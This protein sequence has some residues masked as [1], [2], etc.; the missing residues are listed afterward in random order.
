MIS[1]CVYLFLTAGSWLDKDGPLPITN[2]IEV[3]VWAKHPMLQNP[4]AISHDPYGRL[5]VTEAN[6]RKT[7]D[8]DVRNMRDLEPAPWP[9][10]DYSIQSIEERRSILQEYLA[11][12]SPHNNPWMKDYDGDGKKDWLDLK[13][14]TER[15]N[16]LEDTNGD[17][18]A[19]KATIF[20]ED[21]N[22]ELTGTAGG[23]L[24]HQGKV[25]FTVIPDLWLLE[26][27]D[28]DG[29]ADQR[30]SL[31][32]GHGVHIGQ[33]GHDLHGLTVGPDGRIYWSVGDKGINVTSKEGRHFFY[34]NQGL[35]MRSEPDGSNFEVF[36]MGLRNCQEL[37]FDNF[38]N[39]FCV[40]NDG[41]F[42]GERERLLYVTRDSDTGWRIN[43]QFNHTNKWAKS[44]RLPEYN[45]WMEEGLHVPHFEGQAAYI[46]PPLANYSDGPAGFI[47]NPGTALSEAYED[48]YF[49][50]QFPGQKITAF[51]L[52]PKGAAFEMVNEHNFQGGFMATGFSF[53]PEGALYVA[54]WAGNWEPN[55]EGA[56]VK[57]DVVENERHPLRALTK[58]LIQ[59]D[60]ASLST[61]SLL[62]LLTY[63]DRRVR[64]RAQFELVARKE[65]ALLHRTALDN[66]TALL[67]R[68]H[69]LWGMGQLARAI[70][71]T[72]SVAIADLLQDS[73][74]QVVI[75]TLRLIAEAPALFAD[76]EEAVIA[77]LQNENLQVRFH[78]GQTLGHIGT[79]QAIEPLFELLASEQG[80]DPFIRHGAVTG[81]AGIGYENTLQTAVSHPSNSVRLGAVLALRRLKSIHTQDFLADED[82]LIVLAAA[83]AIHDDFGIPDAMPALARILNETPHYS[84]EALMRRVLNANLRLG[85]ERH[86]NEVLTFFQ[87]DKGNRE[88]KQEALDILLTWSR[89][90]MLD[91]VERRHRDIEPRAS[92]L[93]PTLLNQRFSDLFATGS[94]A[95]DLS[96][97]LLQHYN[98]PI[99][100]GM[101][102]QR[103]ADASRS[104]NERIE[105]F[106]VLVNQSRERKAAFNTAFASN[107]INL[108]IRA[109]DAQLTH[110]E[111]AAIKQISHVLNNS[112]NLLQRQHAISLLANIQSR[113]GLKIL[114]G[115]VEQLEQDRID[116]TEQLD[117]FLAATAHPQFEKS[118]EAVWQD[119]GPGA[120]APYAF[121][122]Y[123]GNAI[124]GETVFLTHAAAQ[125]IRCHAVKEGDGSNVG[126][127]LQGIGSK[128]DR[129]YLLESLVSPSATIAEGFGDDGS[130]SVMPPMGGLL[131]PQE[132][133]DLMAYLTTL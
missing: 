44:Q 10:L 87:S 26:D 7:V 96:I 97:K 100:P 106:N 93:I 61:D 124:Q 55:S 18:V 45:P 94:R 82:P 79:E 27:K 60:I 48:Y 99:E 2:S 14:K 85:E 122:S 42:K 8:L 69:A 101:L 51:Q 91:R 19:D 110:D 117:V 126:P 68:V 121:S 125:C 108:K 131:S 43:W 33:G 123:G 98:I 118:L 63:S 16:L 75:Q 3:E 89:P 29:V 80:K 120:Q 57:L 86:A 38:G 104:T 102:Q 109:L 50:T 66:S 1:A 30:E 32:T 107:D 64:Q 90:P 15:V 114:S 6:R 62:T 115:L 78:A 40:D 13:A 9:A 11:V 129:G 76:S 112:S 39:L 74:S 20:A 34:P 24:W 72:N 31:V 116:H 77:L 71:L 21:F 103:L 67:A 88:L 119:A 81:L 130:I 83:R 54:D 56:I 47:K 52:Q 133:R 73:N 22:T 111:S 65:T 70:T 28:K 46:T 92:S 58:Q 25:Y 127:I 49:L 105:I 59:T 17:G 128:F 23:V 84:N 12:N 95:N 132:L 53:G 36:A 4:V 41:D 37:S 113:N 5:Y 35:V